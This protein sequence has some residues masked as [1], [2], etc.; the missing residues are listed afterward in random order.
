M[1]DTPDE[2]TLRVRRPPRTDLATT[3]SRVGL[4][5]RLF[6]W[7]LGW[8]RRRTFPG[9]FRC[10]GFFSPT[11]RGGRFLLGGFLI[12]ITSVIGDIKSRSLEDKARAGAEQPL[13]FSV[14][15]LGQT[16]KILRA[17]GKRFVTH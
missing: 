11:R 14:P 8:L 5:G 7:S 15:P 6:F 1:R 16:A 3:K 4:F 17:F 9:F 12:R 13:Y 2:A 10:G